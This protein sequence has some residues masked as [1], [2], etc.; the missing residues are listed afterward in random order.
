MTEPDQDLAPSLVEQQALV[1]AVAPGLAW[2]E[3]SRMAACGGCSSSSACATP[4]LGSLG[5][6]GGAAAR[7]QVAD[8]LGLRVGDGVVVGIPDGTLTRAAALAYLLPPATLVLTAAGA[9]VLGLGDLGSA[10]VGLVGLTLGLVLT[11]LLIG[12]T[13]AR[14]SY[15][16]VLV[17]RRQGGPGVP[18]NLQQIDRGIGS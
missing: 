9:G 1:V 6:G 5:G 11:R 7:I 15:R 4:V 18:V 2:L 10:L 8:H 12:G 13:A 14:G 17:R 16:P 3:T